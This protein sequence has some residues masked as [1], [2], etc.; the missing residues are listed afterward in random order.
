M[1]KHKPKREKKIFVDWGLVL[2]ASLWFIVSHFI[3][4]EKTIIG[5]LIVIAYHVEN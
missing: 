4:V 3:G 1:T 5:L 2:N